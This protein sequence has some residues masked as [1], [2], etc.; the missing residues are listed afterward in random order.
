MERDS[1]PPHRFL[2]LSY[3]DYKTNTIAGPDQDD[4]ERRRGAIWL[5]VFVSGSVAEYPK[6][7][8]FIPGMRV[9]P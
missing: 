9:S 4:G 1:P 7:E 8:Y 6:Y 3:F 2:L 5:K